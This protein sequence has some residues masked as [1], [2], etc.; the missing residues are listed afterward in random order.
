MSS[1]GGIRR[2]RAGSAAQGRLVSRYTSVLG[3]GGRADD[4]DF[5]P[6]KGRASGC[7]QRSCSRRVADDQLWTPSMTRMMFLL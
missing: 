4:L 7:W 2:S 5:S 1:D 6:W 3:E